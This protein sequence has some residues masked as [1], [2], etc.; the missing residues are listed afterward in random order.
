MN[1]NQKAVKENFPSA[2][3][4]LYWGL[5]GRDFYA[6]LCDK[7]TKITAADGTVYQGVL[8]GQDQYDL[9]I[10]QWNG[11]TLLFAKHSIKFVHEEVVSGIPAK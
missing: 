8:V 2:E 7:P 11:L 5:C 3:P 1:K 4:A 10:R 6:T 9:L